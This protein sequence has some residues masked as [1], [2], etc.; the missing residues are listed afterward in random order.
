MEPL[1]L[2]QAKEKELLELRDAALKQ[3]EAQ[4]SRWGTWSVD[5]A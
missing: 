3:L 4:V 5:C 1:S 2:L